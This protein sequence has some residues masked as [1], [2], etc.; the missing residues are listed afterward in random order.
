MLIIVNLLEGM[1]KKAEL[2]NSMQLQ[3]QVLAITSL[4][5]FT[6]LSILA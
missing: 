5:T 2:S 6:V 3:Q 1:S 4:W